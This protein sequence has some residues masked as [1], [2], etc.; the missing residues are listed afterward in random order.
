M[1]RILLHLLL[2]S[3]FLF[4]TPRACLSITSSIQPYNLSLL[5]LQSRKESGIKYWN[6]CLSS[7]SCFLWQPTQRMPQIRGIRWWWSSLSSKR[8]R[9]EKEGRRRKKY[10]RWIHRINFYCLDLGSFERNPPSD[11]VQRWRKLSILLMEKGIQVFGKIEEG[12]KKD[13]LVQKIWKGVLSA[14]LRFPS[15][16]K[17][18]RARKPSFPSSIISFFPVPVGIQLLLLHLSPL[19]RFPSSFLTHPLLCI[20]SSTSISVVIR[21]LKRQ[22]VQHFLEPSVQKLGGKM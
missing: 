6:P 11:E 10:M 1:E 8:K 20:P 22:I 17:K 9:N 18:R 2:F 5:F 4:Q 3:F 14:S 13:V 16:E 21:I 19:S 7:F 12:E 15:P